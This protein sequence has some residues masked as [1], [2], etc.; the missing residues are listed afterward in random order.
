MVQILQ[1]RQRFGELLGQQ[2]GQGL[3]NAA[4]SFTERL[5]MKKQQEQKSQLL[6]D[7]NEA[8]KSIYGI[9]LG[10][11]TDPEIRQLIIGEKLKGQTASEKNAIEM[12]QKSAP[13]KIG[14]DTIQKMKAIKDRGNLGIGSS[15]L[16][17]ISTDA[18]KDRAEYQQL[19]RSLIPLVSAGVGIRNEK[20]F[21]EYKKVITD[22]SAS[23]DAIDGA[24]HGL[25]DLLNRQMQEY[26]SSY[27]NPFSSES[28]GKMMREG[29]SPFDM[30]QGKQRPPLS[31]FHR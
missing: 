3:G 21:E 8:L 5:G 18:R 31:S 25:E 2:I 26:S 23:D 14:L 16:S 20:E 28:M 7:E 27:S 9:D 12:N 17:A 29:G 24:L 19:G 30:P 10:Q 6:G 11:I 13:L 15:F 1:P 22:P 4:K